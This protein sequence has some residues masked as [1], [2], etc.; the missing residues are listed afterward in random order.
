VKISNDREREKIVFL[1]FV[2][3]DNVLTSRL[4]QIILLEESSAEGY[5]SS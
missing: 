3:V 2:V 5:T 1:K 4:L